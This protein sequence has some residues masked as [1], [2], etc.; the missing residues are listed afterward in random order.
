MQA[1]LPYSVF[2]IW[3]FVRAQ[4]FTEHVVGMNVVETI[5]RYTT[6]HSS[7]LMNSGT[8]FSF[9]DVTLQCKCAQ[10]GINDAF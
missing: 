5:L 9:L 10:L 1:V 4:L 2:L 8:N 3:S 7:L 6:L